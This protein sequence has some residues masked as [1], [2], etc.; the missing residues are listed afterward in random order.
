MEGSESDSE[1]KV[2]QDINHGLRA[3]N[4]PAM[5]TLSNISDMS[6]EIQ[7]ANDSSLD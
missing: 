3:Q 7:G 4:K 1:I 5:N 2:F 6:Q